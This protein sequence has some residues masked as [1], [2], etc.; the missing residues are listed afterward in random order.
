MIILNL[1]EQIRCF[2]NILGCPTI[3]RSDYGTENVHLAAIQI[4]FRMHGD[5]SFA[6]QKSFMYGPS[7]SNIVSFLTIVTIMTSASS[8][9]G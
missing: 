8:V 6:G 7:T 4:A 1:L 2:F 3:L 9:Q 5:D